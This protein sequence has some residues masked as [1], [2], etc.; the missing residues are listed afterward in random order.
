MSY[1]RIRIEGVDDTQ[2]VTHTTKEYELLLGLNWARLE[3]PQD[4]SNMLIGY[5]SQVQKDL[6][7]KEDRQ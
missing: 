2:T 7:E 6:T 1:I 4:V 3:P 5:I